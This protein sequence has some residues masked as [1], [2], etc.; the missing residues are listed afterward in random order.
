MKLKRKKLNLILKIKLFAFYGF[1]N[2][3]RRIFRIASKAAAKFERARL[4]ERLKLKRYKA[5]KIRLLSAG[6]AI[7]ALCAP[8][9]RLFFILFAP[10][11]LTIK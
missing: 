1:K 3:T 8:S 6:F 2:K 9:L 7:T 4:N 10:I 5:L 11:C